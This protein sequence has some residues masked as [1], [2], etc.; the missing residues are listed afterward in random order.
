[1]RAIPFKNM[2][3][4]IKIVK[5]EQAKNRRVEIGNMHV[6]S[7]PRHRAPRS[8]KDLKCGGCDTMFRVTTLAEDVGWSVCPRCGSS[9]IDYLEG[10]ELSYFK[11]QMR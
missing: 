1:M 5:A 4:K 9:N 6:Y 3:D 11:N 10:R 8:T 7:Y 2:K